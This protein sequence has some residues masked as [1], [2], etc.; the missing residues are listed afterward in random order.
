MKHGTYDY[1]LKPI[2][3]N[4]LIESIDVPSKINVFIQMNQMLQK[5]SDLKG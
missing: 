1:I 5:N 3:E 2:E 4:K